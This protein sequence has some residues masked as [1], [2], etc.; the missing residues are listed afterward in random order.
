MCLTTS[1]YRQFLISVASSNFESTFS[2]HAYIFSIALV[3]LNCI[4]HITTIL[5]STLL[6]SATCPKDI[7]HHAHLS[8]DC[9]HS[10]WPKIKTHTMVQWGGIIEEYSFFLL[11]S[12][13]RMNQRPNYIQ[14]HQGE[15]KLM[16]V[17]HDTLVA[18]QTWKNNNLLTWRDYSRYFHK[19]FEYGVR[20]MKCRKLN[21]ISKYIIVIYKI[22]V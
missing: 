21:Y 17:S 14:K 19:E 6:A 8:M 18:M 2:L 3:I 9:E 16:M 10:Q 5:C 11:L 1:L 20:K 12:I 4:T 7:E 15:C 13:D 22:C